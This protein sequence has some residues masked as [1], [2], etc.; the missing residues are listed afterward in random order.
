MFKSMNL[1]LLMPLHAVTIP[2]YCFLLYLT[3]DFKTFH[4]GGDLENTCTAF[5]K[6]VG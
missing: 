6:S 5:L 3:D 1:I 2:M 4:S